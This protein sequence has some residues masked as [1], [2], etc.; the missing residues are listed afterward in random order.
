MRTHENVA[1]PL[2]RRTAKAVAAILAGA[3]LAAVTYNTRVEPGALLVKSV[4]EAGRE[5]TPP[6]DYASIAATVREHPPVAVRGEKSPEA[7]LVV[8][9]PRPS[10]GGPYPIVLWVH[11]GGFISSSAATVKDYAVILAHRGFV[12]ADLDYTIAP[13]ARHPVPVR[14]G[15]AALAFL[16]RHGARYGGDPTKI[17]VGG[18]SAGA[19]IASELAAGETSPTLARAIGIPTSPP[20]TAIRGVV[21]FCGLYDMSTVGQTGFPGLRTYLWAYTGTRNWLRAPGVEHMSTTATATGAYPPT[22][23]SVGDADPF[24]SQETELAAA[25]RSRAVPVTELTWNRSGSGLGHEYQF[26]FSTPQAGRALERTVAFLDAAA[27]R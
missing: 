22:F 24:R 20:S 5:V 11:G 25:L 15:S 7:H 18:D 10:S 16:R 6:S 17:F 8:V 4:F 9:T 14:Q 19:Q 2:A 26:D 1:R 12:V 3:L 21:L 13:A 27:G 23:L